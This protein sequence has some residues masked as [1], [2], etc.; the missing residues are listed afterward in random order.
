MNI[1]RIIALL[2]TFV[3]VCASFGVVYAEDA[4]TTATPEEVIDTEEFHALYAMGFLGDELAT[5]NSQT[6]ITRAQFTGY[7]FKLAGYTPTKYETKDIP[8]ID[9]SEKTLYCNEICAM[10][11]MGIVNGTE[12]EMFSPDAHVTYSQAAKLIVDVLGYKNYTAIKYGDYPDGY[13]I[14]A[15]ELE[16]NDGVKN[17]QWNSELTAE[18]AVKMLYNAGRTEVVEFTGVDKNGNPTYKANGVE[19]LEKRN[20]IYYAEGYMQSNGICSLVA[21]EVTSGVTVI[22][23]I[24]YISADVDLTD[25]LGCKVKYFYKDNE[26]DKKLLWAAPHT[27]FNKILELNA[28]DL[29]INDSDYTLTNFV[30]YTA[31]GKTKSLDIKPYANV[32]Y[33]NSICPIPTINDVKPVTGTMRLIDNDNDD[34]YDTVIVEEFRN[35]VVSTISLESQYIGDKYNSTI[36]L[37]KY[38][39]A[40]IIKNGQEIK[41][42]DIELNTVLSCVEN[43]EKTKIFIYVAT[44]GGKEKLTSTGTYRGKTT[45]NFENGTYPLSASYQS[46][47]DNTEISVITPQPGKE[48]TYL[49]D[50]AGEIAEIQNADTELQYALLMSVRPGEVYEDG[51]VYTRLLLSNGTKTT[52][53]TKK[54]IK[55][56]GSR[57]NSEN[58]LTHPSILNEEGQ[59]K[60]QVVYVAF[61]EEGYLRE[62]NFAKDCTDSTLYPY[63]HNQS[64]FSLDY[65][66]ENIRVRVQDGFYLCDST[67]LFDEKSIVFYKWNGLDGIETEPYAVG[68]RDK[69]EDSNYSVDVY[70]AT[71]NLTVSAAYLPD[72]FDATESWMGSMLVSEVDYVYDDGEEVKRLSGYV[73]GVYKSAIEKTPGVF[74]DDIVR[75]DIVK[76]S[77]FEG[78]ATNA[79]REMSVSDF[80]TKTPKM[81]EGSATSEK[82]CTM[83]APLYNVS[84]V[85]LSVINTA[86]KVETLGWKSKNVLPVVIYDIK[87]DHMYKGDANDIYQIYS[88]KKDGSLPDADDLVMMYFKTRYSALMEAIIIRY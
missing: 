53:I 30:Y 10:Y 78:K 46:L 45:Y 59:F 44:G 70:D 11:E 55:L 80:A 32:V 76:I 51:V 17:V 49:L 60:V 20:E 4:V 2:L 5:A 81:I 15:G 14:M 88:P 22:D 65:S 61:D 72:A 58:I 73:E 64:D 27:R 62:I 48:Y 37:K 66:A 85:G 42:E 33:N 83:Y 69:L 77:T 16:L 8:F 36:N 67:Y 1:K 57:Q 3:T 24:S 39:I 63:A 35:I 13:V 87:E 12:P 79:T 54:K 71:D 28:S 34:C 9:V 25:L 7:L 86:G 29:A 52:G 84:N 47:M 82:K 21:E 74:S 50:I 38:D 23:G 41:L 68:T 19:L 56:D 6:Y 26:A 43:K 18:D 75:G 40:K 31:D